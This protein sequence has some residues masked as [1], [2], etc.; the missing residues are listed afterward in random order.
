MITEVI[1]SLLFRYLSWA[2]IRKL[3]YDEKEFL[4]DIEID[5]RASNPVSF[6]LGSKIPTAGIYLRITNKSQYL[7]AI[8]DRAILGVWIYSDDGFQPII[9]EAHIISK[10]TIK[11]KKSEEILCQIDLNERQISR[12]E[13]IKDSKRLQSTLHVEIHISSSVYHHLWKKFS[14]EN[15]QCK[16][17]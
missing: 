13:K 12:L 3:I 9:H 15:R 7:E 6:S 8:F 17:E 11:Q 2:R 5:V 4:D 1:L 10:K 14:L 16:I